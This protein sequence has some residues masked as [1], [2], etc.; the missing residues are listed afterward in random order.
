MHLLLGE[1]LSGADRGMD[2][3]L[4]RQ[5]LKYQQTCGVGGVVTRDQVME[6][7]DGW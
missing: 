6:T 2:A 7:R 5:E 4:W 1:N 3:V